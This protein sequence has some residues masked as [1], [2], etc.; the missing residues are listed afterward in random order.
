MTSAPAPVGRS[1]RFLISSSTA[2]GSDAD[3]SSTLTL[4]TPSSALDTLFLMPCRSSMASSIRITRLSST[5]IGVAPRYDMAMLTTS[6]S[7]SGNTSSGVRNV[8]DQNPMKKIRTMSRLAATPLRANHSII[9]FT[10]GRP[11]PVRRIRRPGLGFPIRHRGAA[12]ARSSLLG[13]GRN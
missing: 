4:A 8:S 1:T 6:R 10:I 9:P 2:R 5:S 7:N 3:S 11:A 13:L 12:S